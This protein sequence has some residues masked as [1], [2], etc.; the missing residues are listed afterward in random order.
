MSSSL[1][2]LNNRIISVG[3]LVLFGILPARE[4]FERFWRDQE[5]ENLPDD[6]LQ[7]LIEE[8]DRYWREIISVS[9]PESYIIYPELMV[10]CI[11]VR[12]KNLGQFA[13]GA[14]DKEKPEL[15]LR[16]ARWITI[17]TQSLLAEGMVFLLVPEPEMAWKVFTEAN[18]GARA[19]PDFGQLR[20]REVMW[21]C[22]GQSVAAQLGHQPNLVQQAEEELARL[23]QIPNREQEA[24]T[25]LEEIRQE[26]AT[27]RNIFQQRQKALA[28]SRN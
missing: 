7:S 20:L 16:R 13:P 10:T 4:A 9:S 2:E 19:L 18:I 5:L 21:A 12:L 17:L 22:Y 23:L 3:T 15:N 25:Y 8:T 27:F 6:Q 14:S 28:S 26:F 1:P 11:K 24:L